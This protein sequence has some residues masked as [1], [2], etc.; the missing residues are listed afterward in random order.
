MTFSWIEIN[1][2]EFSSDPAAEHVNEPDKR[3][4]ARPET[5]DNRN[6]E[7]AADLGT[8]ALGVLVVAHH[9]DLPVCVLVGGAPGRVLGGLW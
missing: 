3:V 5:L 8:W 7:L 2:H 4:T 9:L 1:S 6:A